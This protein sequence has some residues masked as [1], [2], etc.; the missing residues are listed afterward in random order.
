MRGPLGWG[1][2]LY[3]RVAE[4][5]GIGPGTSV[6]DLGCGEGMFCRLATDRGAR[7]T[8]I[9]AAPEL[10]ERARQ[11]APAAVFRTGDIQALPYPDGVFDVVTC[12]QSILHVA[13]PLAALREAARAT[14][15]RCPVAVTVWGRDEDC[16][17]RV[18]GEALSRLLPPPPHPRTR[19]VQPPPLTRDGRLEQLAVKAGLTPKEVDEVPCPFVYPDQDALLGGLLRSRLGRLAAGR[20][21]EK[22]VRRAVLEALAPYR[23]PDGTYGLRNQ[24]RYLIASA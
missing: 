1:L 16:E 9:D 5:T 7:V 14:R 20:S 11:L 4:R 21:G 17:V 19:R 3:E 23:L 15:P 8:G 12:F 24:F 13:N 18:F 22:A 10:V 6:L 2:P